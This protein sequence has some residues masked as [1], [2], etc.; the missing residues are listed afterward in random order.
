MIWTRPTIACRWILA[1]VLVVIAAPGVVATETDQFTMPRG[2]IFADLG[3]Y[4]SQRAMGYLQAG[5]DDLNNK[6]TLSLKRDPSGAGAQRYYRPF[7]V[8]QTVRDTIPSAV[9]MIEELE[10]IITSPSMQRR[11]P[12]R[13]IGYKP[14]RSIF[15]ARS[16]LDP[17]KPF[18]WHYSA[19]I[20]V[21][22][23]YLGTD[24]IGHF[25]DKG[26]I[27]ARRYYEGVGR[28][29]STQTA[30]DDA[31]AL[32]SGGN[33]IYSE[34]AILGMWSSG[35]YSNADLACDYSGMLFFRNLTEPIEVAGVLRQPMLVRD[36]PYWALA[37]RIRPDTD[38][39]TCFITDHFNEAL[40]PS[41]YRGGFRTTVRKYL[42]S[43]RDDILDWYADANGTRRSR[44][45]F[46][47][48]VDEL[49]T[50]WGVD[51]GYRGDE[52]TIVSIA[53][54]CFDESPQTIFD[55]VAA[56][57]AQAVSQLVGTSAL[58]QRDPS[59]A[60]PLHRAAA[61]PALV[62]Q[63]LDDGLAADAVDHAGRTPLHAA[64]RI[65]S[66]DSINQL[67]AA[68]VR[69]DATDH[70]GWTALHDAARFGCANAASAL[71]AHGADPDARVRLGMTPLML[72]A[73]QDDPAV[74]AVLA[75]AGADLNARD[76]SGWTALHHACAHQHAAV[77]RA[78]LA[79][80]ADADTRASTGAR[81]LH[82]ACRAGAYA[83]AVALADAGA[84][85]DAPEADGM[86]PL[87]EAAFSG[88][89]QLVA[90]LIARGADPTGG[91]AAT[92]P[93]ELARARGHRRTATILWQAID[94]SRP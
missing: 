91:A 85:L 51:Y 36:G 23:V 61:T 64:A 71:L 66:A 89:A 30:T 17:G 29:D 6:I 20:R 21:G 56:A 54:A 79:A 62:G 25:Y 74:V 42:A 45:W 63:L 84:D 69:D 28:G 24:K 19:T 40:N 9:L 88:S 77:A 86:T 37:D 87:H 14:G 92:P 50:Y 72:A 75:R 26:F 46:Q 2:M 81:P 70:R 90:D 53:T 18:T 8:A 52:T 57:D 41:I 39:F 11:Y 83:C 3:P 33:L 27:L 73:L 10:H 15:S 49:S 44:V 65:D 68:G 55:A 16:M 22:D 78:L 1:I 38:Y 35:V 4:F 82:L 59:G 13:L 12:G 5:V 67:L 34:D 94:R 76:A 48:K 32:G 47:N 93:A 58:S 31:I 7:V 43:H 80:G 60:T